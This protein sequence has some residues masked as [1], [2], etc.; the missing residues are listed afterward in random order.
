MRSEGKVNTSLYAVLGIL[1]MGPQTGYDIKKQ[2]ER[3]TRYFWNENYGQIYP[4]LNRLLE[5][6]D[7]T[8][9]IET[10]EGKPD[11]KVYTITEQGRTMLAEW[12]TAPMEYSVHE[13]KNELLL[14]LFF[15]HEVSPEVS[16]RHILDYKSNLVEMLHVFDGIEQSIR[17]CHPQDPSLKYWLITINYGKMQI[18]AMVQWCEESLLQL[19]QA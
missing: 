18:N 8:L 10:Q 15:G 17:E 19:E 16:I 13:K 14:R 2:M 12:L 6:Q 3:S 1:S 4:H 11:R 9:H 7:V 5:N